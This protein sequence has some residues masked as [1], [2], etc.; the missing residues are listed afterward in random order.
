M[1]GWK[2]AAAA[3][4]ALVMGGTAHAQVSGKVIQMFDM[5]AQETVSREASRPP[6]QGHTYYH[7]EVGSLN[8]DEERVSALIGGWRGVVTVTGFCDRSC[9]DLDLFVIDDL[10]QTVISDI[11]VDAR[12]RVTF[13]ALQDRRYQLRVR[14]YACEQDPCYYAVGAYYGN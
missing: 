9:D 14:M 5:L 6:S 2:L 8:D 4:A 13:M 12:P 3:A 11:S 10:G 1:R 7:G